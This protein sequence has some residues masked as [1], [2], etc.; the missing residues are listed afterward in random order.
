[1]ADMQDLAA[2][3]PPEFGVTAIEDAA[4]QG[5]ARQAAGGSGGRFPVAL[6]GQ[7]ESR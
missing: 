1:M 2:A 5:G 6:A 4:R 7:K 3:A